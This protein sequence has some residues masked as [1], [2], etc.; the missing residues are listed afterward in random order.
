MKYTKRSS[1][2]PRQRFMILLTVVLLAGIVLA[3]LE[4]TNVTHVF[5][6]QPA[7]T[8]AD[9]NTKGE[10][11]SQ[12]ENSSQSSESSSTSNQD[13]QKSNSVTI[14]GPLIA[15]RGTFVS[16]HH[17]NLSGN[18]APNLESSAC[19]TTPNASCKITFTKNG[20]TKS[21]ESRT[22]DLNGSAYWDWRLQDVGLTTGS[23]DITAIA[24]ANGKS[25]TTTDPLKLEVAP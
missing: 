8:T 24:A 10:A 13:S 17:P 20:V 16:N 22:T 21:L 2:K 5:H 15:P 25:L 14:T 7:D 18:P 1:A 6:K 3:L 12:D 11:S 4:L 23:W 9:S 19:T